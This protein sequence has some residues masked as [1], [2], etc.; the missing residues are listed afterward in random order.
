[1][2]MRMLR[3]RRTCLSGGEVVDGEPIWSRAFDIVV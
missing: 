3:N 1:M 2:P